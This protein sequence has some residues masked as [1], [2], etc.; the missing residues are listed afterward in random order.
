M[1]FPLPGIDHHIIN[2]ANELIPGLQPWW[3]PKKLIEITE[4]EGRFSGSTFTT[5]TGD[6]LR[7][8]NVNATFRTHLH[9][10]QK[11]TKLIPKSDHGHYVRHQP[12]T[13]QDSYVKG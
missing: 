1:V 13:A 5:P 9:K 10:V 6:L 4:S 2:L 8:S 3:W 11:K 7:P 12:H